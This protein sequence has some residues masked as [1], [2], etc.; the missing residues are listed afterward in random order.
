MKRL[1]VVLALLL[2]GIIGVGF[3]RGWFLLSTGDW[4]HRPQVTFSVDPDKIRQDGEE[5]KHLGQKARESVGD[6]TD[7]AQ[8]RG[9]R[10]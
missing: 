8:G 7:E 9:R 4:D 1:L 2:A 6:R 10:P 5:V 3:V